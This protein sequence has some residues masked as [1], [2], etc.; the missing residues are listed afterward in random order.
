MQSHLESRLDLLRVTNLFP[1]GLIERLGKWIVSAP[2]EK[3]YRINVLRW[4]KD[5][6]ADENLVI[7]LFLH[8]TQ[9]GIVDMVWSVLCTQC[10]ILVSSQG[11]LRAMSKGKR[12]CRL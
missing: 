9:A 5:V 11:G 8:G 1:P 2:E 7:D 3:L 12:H 10:G 6:G 4:A